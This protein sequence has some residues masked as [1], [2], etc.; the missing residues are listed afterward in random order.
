M[1]AALLHVQRAYR[2]F[3]TL[4]GK[5]H[6]VTAS[7]LLNMAIIYQ[8]NYQFQIALH[9]VQSALERNIAALG[10]NH[11]QIAVVY[12]SVAVALAF[13]NQYRQAI[14]NEKK[15]KQIF[16][17]LL[18]PKHPRITQSQQWLEQF[19]K[20]A[21]AF[22]SNL[23]KKNNPLDT[24]SLF[25]SI[26]P[27]SLSLSSPFTWV[28]LQIIPSYHAQWHVSD[29]LYLLEVQDQAP[30]NTE[31]EPVPEI[32]ASAINGSS[33]RQVMETD[34]AVAH[35]TEGASSDKRKDKSKKKNKKQGKK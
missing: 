25:S 19:T 17:S 31:D 1:E 16:V 33:I 22:E 15:C 20:L 29:T 9:L 6:P 5:N 30:E 26:A 27:P 23:N 8:E 18:N 11:V 12:H 35:D 14:D 21:V 2:L 7:A 28:N 10:E 32:D 34:N 4:G 13:L 24:L 3:E